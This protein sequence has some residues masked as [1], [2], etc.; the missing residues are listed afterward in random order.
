MNS[1]NNLYSAMGPGLPGPRARNISYASGSVL[2]LPFPTLSS[3]MFPPLS[4]QTSMLE[5]FNVHQI[6]QLKHIRLAATD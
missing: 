3:A 1:H 6:Q 4:T 5:H 2:P